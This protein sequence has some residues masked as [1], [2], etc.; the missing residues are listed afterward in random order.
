MNPSPVACTAKSSEPIS[1]TNAISALEGQSAT[2]HS[3]VNSLGEMLYGGSDVTM[4]TQEQN[5]AGLED[6]LTE[7]V[8]SNERALSRLDRIITKL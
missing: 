4:P 8:R 1:I 2:L 6:H 3:M 5:C 7:L